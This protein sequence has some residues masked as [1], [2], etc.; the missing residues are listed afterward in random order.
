MTNA[1]LT[2]VLSTGLIMFGIAYKILLVDGRL[3][4]SDFYCTLFLCVPLAWVL[5]SL[6]L[7]VITHKGL[8][9]SWKRIFHENEEGLD[10]I[11]W[12][13]IGL[14]IFKAAIIGLFFAFPWITNDVNAAV[15]Y[16]V[17]AVTLIAVT[18]GIGWAFVYREEEIKHFVSET[19][20]KFTS[21]VS[22]ASRFDETKSEQGSASSGGL[23]H[24]LSKVVSFGERASN[25]R[26]LSTKSLRHGSTRPNTELAP[27]T[28]DSHDNE[29]SSAYGSTSSM[30]KSR[31]TVPEVYDEMFDAVVLIDQKGF[32]VTVNKTAL[33][34]F[35]YKSKAE[36]IDQNVSV[37]VGGGEAKNHD[38]Y[39]KAFH[40]KDKERTQIGRQRI[41]KARRKDRSEFPCIIGIKK[42]SNGKFLIGYIRDMTGIGGVGLSST[43]SLESE[44]LNSSDNDDFEVAG[45]SVALDGRYRKYLKR[46]LD[47]DLSIASLWR[48]LME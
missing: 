15:I 18:R 5:I 6:E 25:R 22:F 36:L 2:Q 9:K 14:I 40:E 46:I 21:K 35:G 17:I 44:S 24:R 42:T 20:R 37:L 39:L 32:I 28:D 11:Y 3:G 10:V 8:K 16:G 38:S 29:V 23:S 45:A 41:L 13:L 47:D 19:T 7:M 43:H 34:I 30:S 4:L 33:E 27:P 1:T 26:F 12:P 31:N 48:T